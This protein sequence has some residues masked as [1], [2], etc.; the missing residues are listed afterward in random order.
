MICPSCS[1]KV[2]L[3]RLTGTDGAVA[4]IARLAIPDVLIVPSG[5]QFQ[6]LVQVRAS[7]AFELKIHLTHPQR[8]PDASHRPAS[9]CATYRVTPGIYILAAQTVIHAAGTSGMT[10][11]Q[12]SYSTQLF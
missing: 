1:L 4:E 10:Q 12:E 6:D 2:Q 5:S 8:I 3:V 7:V 11:G 9:E